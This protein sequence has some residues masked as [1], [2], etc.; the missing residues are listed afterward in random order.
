M[1]IIHKYNIADASVEVWVKCSWHINE[2]EMSSV[3]KNQ[4]KL[5]CWIILI[6]SPPHIL[7]PPAPYSRELTVVDSTTTLP[8]LPSRFLVGFGSGHSQQESRGHAEIG[9]DAYFPRSFPTQLQFGNDY[10]PP[11]KANCP[12]LKSQIIPGHYSLTCFLRP[13]DRRLPF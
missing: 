2:K 8:C 7:S 12:I 3:W 10:I 4:K 13:R 5:L 1:E 6:F 9:W 11:S